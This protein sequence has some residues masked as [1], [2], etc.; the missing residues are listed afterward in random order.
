VEG[1][2]A[3]VSVLPD[4]VRGN[5]A[6]SALMG[7]SFKAGSIKVM[8]FDF[9]PL[10]TKELNG[11]IKT[12]ALGPIKT[13]VGSKVDDLSPLVSGVLMNNP[14]WSLLNVTVRSP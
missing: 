8:G 6:G 4:G 11:G 1:R 7:M 2:V 10:L 9:G 5:T 13:A 12:T 3:A 14:L